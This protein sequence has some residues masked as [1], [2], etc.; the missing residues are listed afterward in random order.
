MM[1]P[2]PGRPA[3]YLRDIGAAGKGCIVIRRSI[4][5]QERVRHL[6][7]FAISVPNIFV[8]RAVR[9]Q[10][11]NSRLQER[12]EKAGQPRAASGAAE[13]RREGTADR[14]ECGKGRQVLPPWSENGTFSTVK[15]FAP[16]TDCAEAATGFRSVASGD[17]Q[18]EV[19]SR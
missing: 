6:C 1:R 8:F 18:P 15:A 13:A 3:R 5:L 4:A 7:I 9:G 11:R 2:E 17:P 16:E 12:S 10:L 19:Y 14:G